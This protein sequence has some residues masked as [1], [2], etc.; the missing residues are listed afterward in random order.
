MASLVTDHHMLYRVNGEMTDEGAVE[1]RPRI[2]GEPRA[3]QRVGA[4][5]SSP[6]GFGAVWKESFLP[7]TIPLLLVPQGAIETFPLLSL[8]SP[9]LH[10][11]DSEHLECHRREGERH[12]SGRPPETIANSLPSSGPSDFLL[13]GLTRHQHTCSDYDGVA[14][15]YQAGHGDKKAMVPVPSEFSGV[16]R[17]LSTGGWGPRWTRVRPLGED[18]ALWHHKA[19]EGSPVFP[20]T[21]QVDRNLRTIWPRVAEP[22]E[23]ALPA[24]PDRTVAPREVVQIAHVTPLGGDRPGM[25]SN[26]LPGTGQPAPVS[27]VPRPRNPGL[28]PKTWTEMRGHEEGS[29]H[30]WF[31]EGAT[32]AADTLPYSVPNQ[33][34][35]LCHQVVSRLQASCGQGLLFCLLM[36]G[37]SQHREQN[38]QRQVH[39]ENY[40][41]YRREEMM[42]AVTQVV[43]CVLS[44]QEVLGSTPS[45]GPENSGDAVHE[46]GSHVTECLPA[47]CTGG[48]PGAGLLGRRTIINENRGYKRKSSSRK[49]TAGDLGPIPSVTPNPLLSPSTS[50][51]EET[52]GTGPLATRLN[53]EMSKLPPR[54]HPG[55]L[56]LSWDNGAGSLHCSQDWLIPHRSVGSWTG[57][58]HTQST[59]TVFSRW[60]SSE[61]PWRQFACNQAPAP[62]PSVLAVRCLHLIKQNPPPELPPQAVLRNQYLY[63]EELLRAGLG[64]E[65]E[66]SMGGGLDSDLLSFISHSLSRLSFPSPSMRSWLLSPQITGESPPPPCSEA[67]GAALHA[68]SVWIGASIQLPVPHGTGHPLSARHWAGLSGHRG[69]P[70][71]YVPVF[72]ELAASKGNSLC[73]GPGARESWEGSGWHRIGRARAVRPF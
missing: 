30:C 16:S 24:C 56:G 12:W 31:L 65:E 36:E 50:P 69:K 47:A 62:S 27:V 2:C 7:A 9:H 25:L 21:G 54:N 42:G 29:S 73:K 33:V 37:H 57:E 44:V 22:L 26:T 15:R 61:V 51:K 8:W 19:A 59:C 3:G 20:Q 34:R 53:P 13:H 48:G 10:T 55:S 41:G 46:I 28:G 17:D 23:T 38:E 63:K 71:R 52:S 35:C 32:G 60:L 45:T 11:R 49:G 5:S 40:E 66:N 39:D 14:D 1:G 43:E 72:S 18:K 4:G 58:H 64:K 68:L 70:D 67:L 6:R